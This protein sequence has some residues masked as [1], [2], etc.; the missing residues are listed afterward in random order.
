M[1]ANET[2]TDHIGERYNPYG[3]NTTQESGYLEDC[4]S[5]S[6]LRCAMGDLTGKLGALGLEPVTTSPHQTYS[7]YDENLHLLGPFTSEFII[8]IPIILYPLDILLT[9]CI[10][11]YCI[12]TVFGRSIVVYGVGA[13]S[14]QLF[15]CANIEPTLV[16]EEE[17]EI[18]FP[19]NGTNPKDIDRCSF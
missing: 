14:D 7:F 10:I 6:Q 5:L 16:A 15:G 13:Q 18:S 11:W 8:I 1:R 9:M 12:H 3:V 2:C 4:S 17:V 19:R